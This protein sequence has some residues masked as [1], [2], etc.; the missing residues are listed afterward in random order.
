V[1]WVDKVLYWVGLDVGEENIKTDP[2]EQPV[3]KEKKRE[4]V[5]KSV[6][7]TGTL[8]SLPGRG[9]WQVVAIAPE[10][11]DDVQMIADHLK[12]R[13]P[14]I[15]NLQLVDKD[16]AQKI[17]NFLSGTVYALDGNMHRIGTGVLFFSPNNVELQEFGDLAYALEQDEN[18]FK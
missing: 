5:E 17:L 16:V 2:E 1:G 3:K 14:V 8:V 7:S 18:L 15:L 13:R 10:S 11:F 9:Q 12:E 6:Q 4:R